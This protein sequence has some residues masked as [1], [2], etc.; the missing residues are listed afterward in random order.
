MK[1]IAKKIVLFFIGVKNE[2]KK[3]KWV[4]KKEMVKYSAATL[5][6]IF[7]FAAFFSLTDLL[8]SGLKLLVGEYL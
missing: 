3:V 7:I 2:M 5:A 4:S 6:F 1:K 8:V